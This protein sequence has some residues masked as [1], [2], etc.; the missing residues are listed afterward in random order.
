MSSY[1]NKY[2]YYDKNTPLKVTFENEPMIRKM[3]RM[4]YKYIKNYQ[5]RRLRLF[6]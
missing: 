3:E 4:K 2:P 1:Q 5:Q 6:S